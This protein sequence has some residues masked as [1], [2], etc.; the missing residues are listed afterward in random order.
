MRSN[1]A[2]FLFFLLKMLVKVSLFQ[3]KTWDSKMV[4]ASVRGTSGEKEFWIM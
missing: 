1:L 4:M 2:R 3:V